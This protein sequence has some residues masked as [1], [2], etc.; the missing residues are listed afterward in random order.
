M[1]TNFTG[2]TKQLVECLG[3]S[4][5]RATAGLERMWQILVDAFEQMEYQRMADD[6]KA[7]VSAYRTPGQP[8]TDCIAMLRKVNLELVTQAAINI[9]LLARDAPTG[10][11]RPAAPSRPRFPDKPTCQFARETPANRLA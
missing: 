6:W 4:E 1:Y 5:I 9:E 3:T 2:R 10:L 11:D 7:W 8:M